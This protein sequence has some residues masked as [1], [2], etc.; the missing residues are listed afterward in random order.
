MISTVPKANRQPICSG[1]NASSPTFFMATSFKVVTG[2][3]YTTD[4]AELGFPGGRMECPARARPNEDATLHC[5]KAKQLIHCRQASL[6][7]LFAER[8][9]H[10]QVVRWGNV[11][12]PARP[13]GL[14]DSAADNGLFEPFAIHLLRLDLLGDRVQEFVALPK[15]VVSLGEIHPLPHELLAVEVLVV[16]LIGADALLVGAMR[17]HHSVESVDD[18]IEVAVYERPFRIADLAVGLVRSFGLDGGDGLLDHC[19]RFVLGRARRSD[20]RRSKDDGDEQDHGGDGRLLRTLTHGCLQGS[21]QRHRAALVGPTLE[22]FASG[23]YPL[24][25]ACFRI[26]QGP[27]AA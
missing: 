17:K 10:S 23:P 1:A 6:M 2:R 25:T 8:F 5:S 24:F 19:H 20:R 7:S 16:D 3:M 27:R 15:A 12:P 14:I 26:C 22:N 9:S 21:A 4:N 11:P 13:S 18:D